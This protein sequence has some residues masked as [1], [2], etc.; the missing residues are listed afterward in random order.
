MTN[1][2]LKYFTKYGTYRFWFEDIWDFEWEDCLIYA[3]QKKIQDISDSSISK[4]PLLLTLFLKFLDRLYLKL[5]SI[6]NS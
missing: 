3:K 6:K 1:N 5:S 4:P 2:S